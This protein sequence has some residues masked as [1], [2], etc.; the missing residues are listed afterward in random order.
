MNRN[1]RLTQ[2]T[3]FKR[4]RRCGKSY[5]HPLVVLVVLSVD[6]ETS[7]IGVTAGRLIG[8][9]VQRNR[10]KRLVREAIRPLLPQLK[11]G[12]NIIAIARSPILEADFTD[13]QDG[14]RELFRKAN[15]IEEGNE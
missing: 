11:P 15:L 1:F 8:K 4:V 2:S 3:E 7:R 9:A 6:G 5:A 12:W 14:V 10:A 13:I